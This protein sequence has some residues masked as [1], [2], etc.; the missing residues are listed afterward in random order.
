LF[1]FYA[2]RGIPTKTFAAYPSDTLPLHVS[3]TVLWKTHGG[4][5]FIELRQL[6]FSRGKGKEYTRGRLQ[7]QRRVN[8]LSQ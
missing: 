2:D 1:S 6:F 4:R 3:S 8:K 5:V 7:Q